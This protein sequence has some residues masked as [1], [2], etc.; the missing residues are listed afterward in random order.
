MSL[1]SEFFYAAPAFLFAG[2]F[3]GAVGVGLP[4]VVV[5]LLS[6]VMPTNQAVALMALPAIATNL[7]QMFAGPALVRLLR[8]FAWFCLAVFVGTFTTIGFMTAAR[9]ATSAALGLVLAAYG[10]Y[11]LFGPR[12]HVSERTERWL[13]PIVGFATG[14]LSGAT[15][16]FV[17]P[18][19]PYLTALRMTSEEMVQ[20]LGLHAFVCPLSLTLALASHGAFRADV[21]G[22]SALALLPA[23][24]GMYVGVKL[25]RRMRAD[26]FMR[27]F[28]AALILLGGYMLWRSL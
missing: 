21:A 19:V 15:G 1:P 10:L 24:A 22:A 28:F 11:G 18:T 2:F 27:W 26:V 20:A 9:P 3:K 6:I 5:G 14:M 12:F 4:T 16:I 13:S 25:R 7:W 23:F 17:V 8:R